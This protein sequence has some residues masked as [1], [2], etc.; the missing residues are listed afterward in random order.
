MCL[1]GCVYPWSKW[2]RKNNGH[3][4]ATKFSRTQYCIWKYWICFLFCVINP[5]IC[6]FFYISWKTTIK[7]TKQKERKRQN[8]LIILIKI[9]Y[10]PCVQICFKR[11]EG[12]EKTYKEQVFFFKIYCTRNNISEKISNWYLLSSKSNL[13]NHLIGSIS[14]KC[15]KIITYN[16]FL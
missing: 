12:T 7:K 8:A 11:V 9:Y 16:L 6:L 4:T 13:F 14:I 3:I 2:T 1:L 10:K 5:L 15:F